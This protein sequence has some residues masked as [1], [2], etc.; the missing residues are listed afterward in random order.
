M[1]RKT[2][3]PEYSAMFET[4]YFNRVRNIARPRPGVVMAL[5]LAAI[6]LA[7]LAHLAS[8]IKYDSFIGAIAQ[9]RYSAICWSL[10][11]TVIS[12]VSLILRDYIAL[13]SAGVRAPAA[14]VALAGFC[15]TALG[16]AVGYGALTGGVVR[17][18]IY[19]AVGIKPEAIG[20]MMLFIAA[21]FAIGSASFTA[22]MTLFD[23]TPLVA[24]TGWPSG[25]LKAASSVILAAMLAIVLV[26]GR[27]QLRFGRYAIALPSIGLAF[28]QLLVTAIDL[29]AASAALWVLLP[30]FPLGFFR[31]TVIFS[32]ATSL[33]VLSHV[34][35]GIG[36]FEAVVLFALGRDI[37][38]A[39]AA[40]ALIVYRGVYFGIPLMLSGML[41]AVSEL[42]LA[43]SPIGTAL[44]APLSRS[45]ARLSPNFVSAIAFATG[46]MLVC[47]GATP[48]FED[49]LALLSH[50]IPLWIIE[51]SNFLGS[52]F[53]ILLLFLSRGLLHRLSDA[54]WLTF[55]LSIA[56]LGLS[57][58]KGLAY[59][60]VLILAILLG[61]LLATRKQFK[62]S[63][64]LLGQPMTGGWLAAISV[65]V[66]AAFCLLSFAFRNAPYTRD[67]WWQFELD[68]QAP[69]ALR[70]T[71]GVA[72][73]AMSLALAQLLRPPKGQPARPNLEDFKRA[74]S[75]IR[76]QEHPVAMLALMGDKSLMFSA[77]G[78]A[79]IMFMCHGRS[80]VALSDPVGPRNEWPELLWRFIE[81]ADW[82]GGRTAFYQV[83]PENL[84][85]YLE[86]GFKVMKLGEEAVVYLSDFDLKGSKAARLRY[87]LSRGERDGLSVELFQ[88]HQIPAIIDTISSISR[89]WLRSQR[90]EEKAF[91]VAAF[92]P[93]FVSS[94]WVGLLRQNGT[95]TAF[96]TV[97]VTDC[98]Q[99][100]V[101]GLMRHLPGCSPYAMEYLFTKLLLSFK[102]SGYLRFSLGIAPLSGIQPRPLSSAWH[103]IGSLIWQHGNWIYNFQGLRQF[104]SKFNPTWEPRYLVA[105]GA[106]GPFIALADVAALTNIRTKRRSQA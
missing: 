84:P 72:V 10:V 80:W 39:S 37:A 25:L 56:S 89:E 12:F 77:A 106:I 79:F 55:G 24:L 43:L 48:A 61:L 81:Q 2:L 68:A 11:A 9:T 103:H 67:L 85:L 87:A 105:S 69:R 1:L 76:S 46:I 15:G 32:V 57:M 99:E 38:P 60:E 18:R 41:L 40:A 95:P 19:G 53:G 58:A 70:A 54:W 50:G 16:N 27:G 33:G 75:I 34:P 94:Q 20:R 6:V 101:V 13:C 93:E 51:A 29:L 65:I 26:C 64:S 49:R 31:F 71:V 8:G 59:G 86:A 4:A 63:A 96:V 42:R 62:R 52:L 97:M 7:L 104:K 5:I 47:S 45:A 23:T 28:A 30:D 82:H 36:V 88:P 22:F 14:A 78:N 66:A 90:M 44:R 3:G 100:A 21:S 74:Q 91:S 35:G 17:Y 92:N 102:E 83:R 98:H 73:L